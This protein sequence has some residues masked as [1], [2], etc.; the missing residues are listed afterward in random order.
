MTQIPKRGMMN[1]Q[2]EAADVDINRIPWTT[3]NV[4]E[5]QQ[6]MNVLRIKQLEEQAMK[7]LELTVSS[8]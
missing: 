7:A 2:T 8:G 6:E 5:I 4:N 3:E 1:S